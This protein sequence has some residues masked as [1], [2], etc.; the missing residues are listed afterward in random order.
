MKTD[1]SQWSSSFGV[2]LATVGAAIGLGT[3]W[4]FPYL[5]SKYGGGIFLLTYLVVC[6]TLGFILVV[7]ELCLGRT[8]KTSTV[9]AFRAVAKHKGWQAIGV[10]NILAI[11]MITWFYYIIGGWILFYI[12]KIIDGTIPLE[13]NV[14]PAVFEDIFA[15]FIASPVEPLFY[16]AL[17]LSLTLLIVVSG[18]KNGIEKFSKILLPIRLILMLALI[19]RAVTF[20]GGWEGV[21]YFLIPDFSKLTIAMLLEALGLGFFTLSLAMGI[22]ITYGS[23]TPNKIN[24]FNSAKWTT[25]LTVF[26]CFLAGLV[27]LPT[28]FAFGFD[29][30]AG[31]GLVF[32]VMPIIFG[33]MPLG[34]LFAILFFIVLYVAAQLSAVAI[35]EV[36][37][38]FFID[39]F[40]MKRHYAALSTAA[41]IFPVCIPVSLSLGMWSG[42][43][44]QLFGKTLF[45]LADYLTFSIMLPI[46]GM[47]LSIFTGWVAWD[48]LEGNLIG[49]G[50][51]P[52]WLPLFKNG[53][54]F[55]V[56]LLILLILIQ[57][58]W[59]IF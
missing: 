16:C 36:I 9:G 43:E 41:V 7:M 1:R 8:A 15:K 39:E 3:I 45:D 57:S 11:W 27:V 22:I 14:N 37:T 54:R 4:R 30:A 33:H 49:E 51:R 5:A 20:P 58:N 52:I 50:S 29:P 53:L 46:G 26:A 28:V 35:S 55:V 13:T 59:P 44:Y 12:V 6:L 21:K 40:H 48:K 17:F 18:V 24:L 23:Y 25:L 10:L 34:L 2:I 42:A 19:A 38:S 31:P 47:L 56:P 32:I